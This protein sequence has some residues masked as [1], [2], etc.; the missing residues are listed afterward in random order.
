[1]YVCVW[2]DRQTDGQTQTKAM[3]LLQSMGVAK[4]WHIA[5]HVYIFAPAIR[6]VVA[7]LVARFSQSFLA[8]LNTLAL[9]SGHPLGLIAFLWQLK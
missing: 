7:D 9:F 2:K 4:E 8:L 6:S 5:N 3:L 1:V